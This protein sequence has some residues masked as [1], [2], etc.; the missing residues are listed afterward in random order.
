MIPHS[1][2]E[3]LETSVFAR[4]V[5]TAYKSLASVQQHDTRNH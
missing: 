3:A 2:T 4:Y 1:K 5:D